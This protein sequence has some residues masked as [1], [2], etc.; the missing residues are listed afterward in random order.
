MSFWAL[1]IYSWVCVE[2]LPMDLENEVAENRQGT[3]LS[4]VPSFFFFFWAK[5]LK[6]LRDMFATLT[7]WFRYNLK[8]NRL[9]S[10]D[11]VP[12]TLLVNG[13]SDIIY[14][15]QQADSGNSIVFFFFFLSFYVFGGARKNIVQSYSNC[16]LPL[17]L[18]LHCT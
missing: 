2:S 7:I 9:T 10:N 12:Y 17:I 18:I 6:G 3:H 11:H 8:C 13:H 15:H 5:I 1:K 14:A 16:L 4:F